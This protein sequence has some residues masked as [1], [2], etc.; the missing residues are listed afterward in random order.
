MG[1]SV[2]LLVSALSGAA[3][4]LMAFG[5]LVTVSRSSA[6]WFWAASWVLLGL[7][8]MAGPLGIPV[9][10]KLLVLGS[11]AALAEGYFRWAPGRSAR[12][13]VWAGSVLASGTV[14]LGVSDILPAVSLVLVVWTFVPLVLSLRAIAH[15]HRRNSGPARGQA[16]SLLYS[17][18]GGSGLYALSWV[19]F[20]S[21]PN[22]GWTVGFPPLAVLGAFLQFRAL[23]HYNTRLPAGQTT[24]F[25]IEYT[26]DLVLFLG[27][28]GRVQAVNPAVP[29]LLGFD[30]ESLVGRPLGAL[31]ADDP[32]RRL[33]APLEALA[34]SSWEGDLALRRRMGPSVPVHL[35]YRRIHNPAREAIGAVLLLY[36][37]GTAGSAEDDHEDKLTALASPRWVRQIL[38]AEFH[39]GRRYST[40]LTVLWVAL[41]RDPGGDEV[42]RRVGGILRAGLRKTDFCGRWGDRE[43]LAVLPGTATDQAAVVSARLE[44][45]FALASAGDA[46]GPGLRIGTTGLDATVETSDDFVA[47]ARNAVPASAAED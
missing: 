1:P 6:V 24:P 23:H 12:V 30:E 40:P 2:A 41:V 47:L 14:V 13:L 16:G 44:G 33:L 32:A 8:C 26:R 11:L 5:L 18:V 39:R 34:F 46:P 35:V 15:V 9:L 25:V 7:G 20:P 42:L 3:L 43:F 38:E 21:M 10:P 4:I 36:D 22:L 17:L 31:A 29:G 27:A 45:L 37:P 19:L 28:D